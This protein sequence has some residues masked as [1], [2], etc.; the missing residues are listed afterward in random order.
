MDRREFLKAA[1]IAGLALNPIAARAIEAARP[2][3][4]RPN[5]VFILIDDLRY[6]LV[7]ATGNP[8]AKTPNIDRIARDGTIFSNAFVTL[9]LCAP[10]RA[11]FLTGQ[12]GHCNGVYVNETRPELDPE[13][14]TWPQLLQK[15]G[16]DTAFIGKWHQGKGS[17]PRK[18]FDHWV[19]FDG[20]GRYDNPIINTNG[21]IKETPGYMTDILSDAAMD[22]LRRDR[23]KPFCLYLPH[24]AVHGPFKPADRYAGMYENTKFPHPP[25]CF[26]NLEGKPAWLKAMAKT[27]DPHN[28]AALGGMDEIVRKQLA[29]LAAV[30]EGVGRILGHLERTGQLD[31]TIIAFAGDNGYYHGEHGLGD[32]RS[33]YEESIRFPLI[34]RYPKM[35]KPGSKIEDMVL[36]IDFAPTM[37][38]LAGI[39]APDAMQGKS[40]VPLFAGKNAAWRKEFFY[41]YIREPQFGRIPSAIAVRTDRWKYIR[42]P[43]LTDIDELYDL[44]N[45]RYELK[46]LALDPKYADTIADMKKRMDRL[47]VECKGKEFWDKRI[48]DAKA[49]TP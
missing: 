18:G 7:H 12:Y 2:K 33:A 32:K 40:M 1:A 30:D 23:D 19:S 27:R 49:A 44:K 8:E 36:N 5:F 6:D 15:A 39:K 41:E 20:Q 34:V 16:Y 10:S 22:W 35:L 45:D 9:S 13:I 46:N 47:M 3:D 37:L 42:Y 29:T 17:Y 43:E 38:E 31:N 26:D 4:P 28:I 11:A 14:P 24:K 25:N 48:A 21:E